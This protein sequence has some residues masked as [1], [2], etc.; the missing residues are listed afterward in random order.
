MFNKNYKEIPICIIGAGGIVRDAHLPAYK[1]AG[2]KV[3][4]ITN[5]NVEKSELLAKEYQIKNVYDSLQEMVRV[6]GTSVVYDFALPASEILPVLELLP[7]GATVLIQKPLGESVIEA[8][9]ILQLTRKKKI[10]AGVNFQMRF[11]P[12]VREAKRMISNGDIGEVTDIEV[13]VNV[14]TPW[15]LW[16]FLF[17]K[18][19][20]E[21]NYHSVHYVDLIRSFLGNPLKIYAHTFK[22]PHSMQLSSVRTTMILDYGDVLRATIHTNHNHDFGYEK[23]Q[24][25]I[26]IE[27]TNGAIRIGFGV[28]I[29]YPHGVPDSFEYVLG[30]TNAPPIWKSKKIEG[31]WFPHAFIGTMEQMLLTKAGLI[32]QPENSIDDA[33]E[34]MRCVEAAYE[35][36]EKGGVHLTNIIL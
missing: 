7:E 36:S 25:Y 29:D 9:E 15:N 10:T 27:G 24:S 33:F 30:E 28:L 2:F 8:K 34:T 14:H 5:R 21:I 26:K 19:R 11:A 31:T 32:E 12:F 16:D 17:M 1:I 22:H 4:G 23:Q 20:M 13:Y 18:A 6:N 3:K 35:S